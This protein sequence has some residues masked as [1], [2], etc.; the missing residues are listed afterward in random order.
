VAFTKW[1]QDRN[2]WNN[3]D[4]IFQYGGQ[5]GSEDSAGHPLDI[6][7][8]SKTGNAIIGRFRDSLELPSLSQ[9]TLRVKSD[10]F[11]N[12]T[13][14]LL[15]SATKDTLFEVDDNGHIYTNLPIYVDDAAADA[16]TGLRHHGHYQ[17]VGN[18]GEFIKP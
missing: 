12:S 5:N 1:G 9:P 7:A 15:L 17:L 3:N 4:L 14:L 13:N 2:S 11:A 10:G 8:M 18:R 16:D 6:F